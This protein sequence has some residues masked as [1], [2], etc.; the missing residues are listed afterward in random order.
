MDFPLW[1]TDARVAVVTNNPAPKIDPIAML[2]PP[3]SL[4]PATAAVITSGAPF[5]S[6]SK[7]TPATV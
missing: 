3:S 7:V 2:I 5:P 6:A 4:P 1:I